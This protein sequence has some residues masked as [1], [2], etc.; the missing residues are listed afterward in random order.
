MRK[1]DVACRNGIHKGQLPRGVHLFD[2]LARSVAFSENRR[3]E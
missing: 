3:C 2:P 1:E